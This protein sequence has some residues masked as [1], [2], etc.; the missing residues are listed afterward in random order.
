MSIN[1]HRQLVGQYKVNKEWGQV[2]E[3]KKILMQVFC[4]PCRSTGAVP[5]TTTD[6]HGRVHEITTTHFPIWQQRQPYID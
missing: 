5:Y 6:R 4:R 3:S 2:Q 1:P